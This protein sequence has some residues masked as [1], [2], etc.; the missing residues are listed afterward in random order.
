MR[1]SIVRPFEQKTKGVSKSITMLSSLPVYKA[2][3]WPDSA[4][5]RTTS[6]VW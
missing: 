1:R 2:I 5:A 3:S 6:R 4:T